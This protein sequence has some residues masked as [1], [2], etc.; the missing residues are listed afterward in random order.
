MKQSSEDQQLTPNDEPG[1][2]Q[3]D[4]M[5]PEPLEGDPASGDND[6]A[7]RGDSLPE[8]ERGAE[9][10]WMQDI[11]LAQRKIDTLRAEARADRERSCRS[12]EQ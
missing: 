7:A 6:E 12:N 1:S 2:K 8:L 4:D 10:F 11:R 9:P 5:Q 3:P